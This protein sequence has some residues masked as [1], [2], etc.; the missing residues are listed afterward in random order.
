M[1]A[2]GLDGID[3]NGIDTNGM[4]FEFRFGDREK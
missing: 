1:V 3:T 2:F 4:C